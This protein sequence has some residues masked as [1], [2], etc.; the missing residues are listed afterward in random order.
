MKKTTPGPWFMDTSLHIYG[1]APREA[2]VGGVVETVDHPHVATAT[3]YADGVLILEVRNFLAATKW[4]LEVWQDQETDTYCESCCS[5]APKDD[6]G[7]PIGPVPHR[8]TCQVDLARKAIKRIE[9]A[10]A[11]RC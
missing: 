4:F 5:H 3:S 1:T 7:S 9:A 11:E 6:S 2:D 8:A 10:E